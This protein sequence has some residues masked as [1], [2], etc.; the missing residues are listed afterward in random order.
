MSYFLKTIIILFACCTV[1]G[2]NSREKIANEGNFKTE[3]FYYQP[4]SN[5]PQDLLRTDVSSY[6]ATPDEAVQEQMDN[7]PI[8]GVGHYPVGKGPFP[9]VVIFHGNHFPLRPSHEGY[10]YLTQLLASHGMVGISIDGNFLNGR[11][12]GE[13]DARAILMLRHLQVWRKWNQTPQH[14]FYQ[15]I[16]MNSIG[17]AGHSRGGEAVAVAN[18]FNKTLHDQNDPLH[19]FAF[20]IKGLFAIAPVDGQIGKSTKVV[21]N[22]TNYFVM[23]GSHD[24]DVYNFAGLRM[25][26]RA[27]PVDHDAGGF[28][29]L[30][31][32]HGANH[33]YWNTVWQYSNDGGSGFGMSSPYLQITAE[34][35][36]LLAQI[37]MRA[38]FEWTLQG[39]SRK[40]LFTGSESLIPTDIVAVQQYSDREHIDLN[41]YEEDV[42][43][44]TGTYPGVQNN[45]R[46][47]S[48]FK[49]ASIKGGSNVTSQQTHGAFVTW[50][51]NDAVYE[52]KLPSQIEKL[53]ADYPYLSFRI[54]QMYEKEP[55]HNPVEGQD[56]S[57]NLQ[58]AKNTTVPV[59]ISR[60]TKLVAPVPVFK[61]NY[62]ISKTNMQTVRIPIEKFTNNKIPLKDITIRIKF[63]NTPT[64]FIV[65]DDIQLSK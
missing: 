37:F 64:G 38:F 19:N 40:E 55:Q 50:N 24:G 54:G 21:I 31:F 33:N 49:E 52:I 10:K 63:C 17:L 53:V 7:V 65:M 23:H 27:F 9:L 35:Q 29:S 22:D 39:K 47:M 1:Y 13:M 44:T 41:N 3:E 5:D 11:V 4:Q 6:F 48:Q 25:Y 42:D 14:R 16:D 36:Q 59:K 62:D 20:N 8:S 56:L 30:L 12:S 61:F 60:F 26:D 43:S 28:K 15:K 2:Q 51:S 45:A 46:N 34:K 57:L 58:L 18:L 32:V